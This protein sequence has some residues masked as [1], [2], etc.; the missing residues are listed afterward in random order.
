[1]L[2]IKFFKKIIDSHGEKQKMFK[3]LNYFVKAAIKILNQEGF[4]SFFLKLKQFLA[5]KKFNQF[6]LNKKKSLS[7]ESLCAE[8]FKDIFTVHTLY[9]DDKVQKIRINLVLDALHSDAL[10]GGAATAV[11]VGAMLANQLNTELRIITYTYT[12]HNAAFLA[13]LRLHHIP[14][15]QNYTFYCVLESKQLLPVNKNDFFIASSW[16]TAY[17]V[18]KINLRSQYIWLIQEYEKIF[19]PNGD[20]HVMINNLFADTSMIPLFNTH[21]LQDYWQSAGYL[22]A[23]RSDLCFEPAFPY[24]K[25]MHDIQDISKNKS[26]N[27]KSIML[28]YARPTAY[29]NL[30]YTG[31]D[32]L[33][34][35]IEQGI[36]NTQ[37]WE[38]YFAGHRNFPVIFADGSRPQLLG[39]MDLQTYS[40]FIAKVDLGV[41]LM[42]APCPSYVPLDL[43]ASGAV[44]LTTAWKNKT[45]ASLVKYSDNII[46]AEPN[47]PDLLLGLAQA[48][49]LSENLDKR[50]E[51]YLNHHIAQ[52]WQQTLS[53]VIHKL[54]TQTDYFKNA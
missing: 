49:T 4:Y 1:M 41:S 11:I 2:L 10:Y 5:T 22:S 29:R 52:D 51:N 35:T 9:T 13:I 39:K 54:I 36:I 53:P 8:K 21:I 31:L 26:E 32:L 20:E 44:V 17:V 34:T 19:Y 18:K 46:C 23:S 50:Y 15:P 42:L 14:I 48:I 43:V 45:P 28:F 33:N 24:I 37:K 38:I 7:V 25:K 3:R 16:W 40:N 30:F 12:D 27:Q 6:M 47:K